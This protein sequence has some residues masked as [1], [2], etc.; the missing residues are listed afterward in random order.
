MGISTVLPDGSRFPQQ[1]VLHS[2]VRDQFP[3]YHERRLRAKRPVSMLADVNAYL[4]CGNIKRNKATLECFKCGVQ[5]EIP[6]SCKRRSFCEACAV[7]RQRDRSGF[8]GQKVLGE[9]PVRLWTT[10][11]PYPFRTW[12][13]NDPEMITSFLGATLQRITR[14]I[15]NRIKH[16]HGLSTVNVVHPGAVTVVQRVATNLDGNVHFHSL[17]TDGAYVRLGPVQDLTFLELPPPTDDD[18]ADIAWD[19]AKGVRKALWRMN[20]WEDLPA[21]GDRIISGL[22]VSRDNQA[23]ACRITGVAAG[24]SGRPDGVGAINVDA[25]RAIGRGD[26]QNL[27]RMLEYMLAPAIRDKQMTV[28][29]DSVLLE[30]KRPSADG[31]THR[32]YKFDQILDRLAFMI[33]PRYANLIRFHGVYAPNANLREEVTPRGPE[34]PEGERRPA[35]DDGETPED[36]R[37]WAELGTHSF[38][39]DVMRCRLCGGRMK[40]VALTSDRI[41]YRRGRPKPEP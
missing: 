20:S 29:R 14:Y 12:L 2:L 25:S 31:T 35:S 39:D 9:T 28:Q 7:R 26:R 4:E 38:A 41:T 10:T 18:L 33:P 30:L 3:G 17:F 1:G 23:V 37:A 32:R 11:F 24:A 27:R 36:Y 8:L 19:I 6:L 13:G 21:E 16:V 40:L 15:K 22:L 34:P 5:R